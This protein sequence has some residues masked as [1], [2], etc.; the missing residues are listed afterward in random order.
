VTGANRGLGLETCRQLAR[1]GFRVILTARNEGAGAAAEQVLSGEGLKVEFRQLDV[2]NPASVTSFAKWLG[3]EGR[4]LDVL[5][6]NAGIALDGFDAEVVR[7]TLEVNFF[8]AM[9][10]TDALLPL[11]V[12]GGNVVMVSSGL[13]DLSGFGSEIRDKLLDPDLARD[14]LSKL[15]RSFIH[16]VERGRHREAGWPSSAYRVSKA[17]LNALVRIL[18]REL[19]PRH[20]RVNAVCPG[21]VRTGMGGAH[22]ARSVEQGAASIVWAAAV[23]DGPS[24]GF[25]RDGKPI[26]W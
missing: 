20:V 21:W 16:D 23:A 14:E 22:A 19:A 1:L 5:V 24:G 13:G 8:G 9:R 17:G 26:P 18:A 15:M 4:R 2:A 6:N 3:R 10:V 7:K 12:D 25:F 11:V